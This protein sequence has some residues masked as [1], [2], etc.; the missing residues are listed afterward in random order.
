MAWPPEGDAE[1]PSA[2]PEL[3]PMNSDGVRPEKST[4]RHNDINIGNIMFGDFDSTAHRSVPILK[5]IDFGQASNSTNYF[6]YTEES[7]VRQNMH[8]IAEVMINLI[9]GT[10][11]MSINGSKDMEVTIDGEVRVIRS[12]ARDLDGLSRGYGANNAIIEKQRVWLDNLD[13]DLRN[14]LVRCLATDE[15]MRPGLEELFEEVRRNV[16]EK[17]RRSYQGKR[18][19]DNETDESLRRISRNLIVNRQP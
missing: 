4:M 3:P 12:R 9:G 19:Q 10:V 16:T 17:T 11:N 14:L 13:V 5:L 2:K 7:A 15:G 1:A 18:W 8:R 6:T